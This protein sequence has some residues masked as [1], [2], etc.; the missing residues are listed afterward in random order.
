MSF[1]C[2]RI[3]ISS[4]INYNL[5]TLF[6]THLCMHVIDKNF[7]LFDEIIASCEKQFIEMKTFCRLYV[8]FYALQMIGFNCLLNFGLL[9]KTCRCFICSKHILSATGKCIN[10]WCCGDLNSCAIK[11]SKRRCLWR[12]LIDIAGILIKLRKSLS[13]FVKL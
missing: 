11:L 10:L 8:S 9:M 6:L 2:C 3:G 4:T 7:I 13:S 5:I 12:C 1:L